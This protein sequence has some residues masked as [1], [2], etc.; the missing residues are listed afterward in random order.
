MTAEA[1]DVSS[2]EPSK[3]KIWHLPDELEEDE[4]DFA[5]FEELDEDDQEAAS[6]QSSRS[7]NGCARCQYL[8]SKGLSWTDYH[9]SQGLVMDNVDIHQNDFDVD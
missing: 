4:D 3:Q 7:T 6:R 9:L 1:A 8:Q 2:E 5:L